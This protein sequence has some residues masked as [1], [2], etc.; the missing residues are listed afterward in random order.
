MRGGRPRVSTLDPYLPFIRG[1][2]DQYPRRRATRLF[3]MLERLVSVTRP[4]L[5]EPAAKLN[6]P[7]RT[8]WPALTVWL[9]VNAWLLP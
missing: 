2:L 6:V 1:V 3:E 9:M 8:H 7:R 4:L 5:E